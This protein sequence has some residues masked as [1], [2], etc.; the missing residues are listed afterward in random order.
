M[1]CEPVFRPFQSLTDSCSWSLRQLIIQTNPMHIPKKLFLSITLLLITAAGLTAQGQQMPPNQNLPSSSDV[2]DQEITNLVDAIT[3]I[4]P[5]QREVQQ[6]IQQAVE[7][8][9]ITME[10]FQQM[11]MAMQN[12]QL[13][14]Q[15]DITDE[16]QAM[17]QELQPT[18]M[19]L[20]GEAQ[21]EI[22]SKIEENGLTADRYRQIIMGAQQDPELMQRVQ[23]RLEA[24]TTDSE[25]PQ[26]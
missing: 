24:D 10:R 17:I 14:Q 18:L 23:T 13:A 25:N 4:E 21:Q 2:T 6:Q 20:Q 9:G 7:E 11:M 12:P 22:T 1:D 3:A 16:E 15:V 19:Q 8:K 5:I 26:N